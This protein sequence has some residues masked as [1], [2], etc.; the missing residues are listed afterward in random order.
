MEVQ[1][2]E[3]GAMA[4]DEVGSSHGGSLGWLE[5]FFCWLTWEPLSRGSGGS[6]DFFV[7]VAGGGTILT[8]KPLSRHSLRPCGC[9]VFNPVA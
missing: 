3:S 8:C 9:L 2:L 6:L 1:H 5:L 7:F 4:G